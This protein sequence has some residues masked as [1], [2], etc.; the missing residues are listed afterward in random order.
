MPKAITSKGKRVG[1]APRVASKRPSGAAVQ[2]DA[3]F[4]IVGI[5]ASAGGYEA[6]V[7]LFQALPSDAG[8]AFVL[9]MHLEP[10]HESMLSV[11]LGNVTTMAVAEARNGMPV[12]P[13]HVYVI[14]PNADMTIRRGTLHL[15]PRLRSGSSH[16]PADQFLSSLA[17]DLGGR[18]I[19]VLLSGT[20][21]DG[22]NGLKAIKSEGGVTFA[23]DEATAKHYGMPGSAI[24]AGCVDFVLPPAR[25]AEELA[26][27]AGHPY[28]SPRQDA[29]TPQPPTDDDADI[30]KVIY[31]LRAAT[32]VDFS[33]YKTGTIRRRIAR[34]MA[35]RKIG[36]TSNYVGCLTADRTELQALLHDVLIHVTGFF[37]EPEA[38]KVLQ[39]RIFPQI[40]EKKGRDEAIRVWVPGC[41]TGEEVYSLAICLVEFLEDRV[42]ST[43]IQ[44]FGT[45]I[46]EQAIERARSGLYAES[47]VRDVSPARLRR[48]FRKTSGGYLVSS[49]IREMCIFARQDITKDPPFSHVDLI[50]CRNVLIYM[51]SAL[52]KRVVASFHY[53]LREGGFLL[54]SKSEALNTYSDLFAP[55]ERNTHVFIRKPTA[56]RPAPVFAPVNFERTPVSISIPEEPPFDALKEA[57]RLMWQRFSH[58]GLVLNDNLEILH[59]RGDT[60]PFVSPVSGKASLHVLRMVHDDL[61]LELRSA[62]HRVRRTNAPVRTAGIRLQHDGGTSE[63]DLEVQPLKRPGS[64]ERYFLILFEPS[65][66][67]A[68]PA[69]AGKARRK[70]SAE[71]QR[72]L[73]KLRRELEASREYLQSVVEQQEASNEEL[74]SANEEILS[75][76]EELQSTNEELETA[77]EELQSANEELVTLNETLEM[78]N[79]D[80]GKLTDD[81]NNVLD[82]A[83]IPILIVGEDSRIRR[84]TP[85][86]QGLLN[87]LPGDI[88]RPIGNIRPNVQITDLDALIAKVVRSFT[89]IQQEVQDEDGRWY[90]MRIRPYRTGENKIDGVLIAL[91]DIDAHKRANQALAGSEA[92]VRGLV[93]TLLR[94]IVVIDEAGTIVMV[95]AALEAMFGYRRE[96][97]LG[98]AMEILLPERLRAAHAEHRKKYFLS[99]RVRF[100]GVGLDL[101]GRKQDGTEFPTDVSLS[102][103]RKS[104][105]LLAVASILD[106]TEERKLEEAITEKDK[107]L[108]ASEQELQTLTASLLTAQE[109]ER[110]RL[111]RELHDDLN[112]H[113][114]ALSLNA[115]TLEQRL[116]DGGVR[117]Q[118]RSFRAEVEILSDHIRRLAHQLHPSVLEHFGLPKALR[119]Y[120]EEFAKFNDLKVRYRDS[121]LP[122]S[123]PPDIALCLYRVAQEALSNVAHHSRSKSASVVLAFAAGRIRLVVSDKGAGFDAA[124]ARARPGLGLLSMRERLRLVGGSLSIRTKL[125]EGTRVEAS[126]PLPEESA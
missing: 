116:P 118:I 72:E 74:K 114:A 61:K 112:Q 97:L 37:R 46:D 34:R 93:E 102:Y 90:S 27:L 47:A 77:K 120:C 86:A 117:D 66:Q 26:G 59:F 4:R 30:R 109:E 29:G 101:I 65:H 111:A 80:L 56:G 76:N 22:T 45:D 50:S 40:I 125:G 48:F 100:M 54:L 105:S 58:A 83:N 21:C 28:V 104:D 67:E 41:S 87:L 107:A 123:V 13:N 108:R 16:L 64:R 119:S 6:S 95:N 113:L 94:A 121:D 24:S 5:G 43:L 78:R 9:V 15:T 10:E 23:Q 126:I 8:M 49:S 70:R 57:D 99:P 51:G 69:P 44:V 91:V 98:Q 124:D 35:L 96:E 1:S 110:E 39:T 79:A 33:G 75:S 18:A 20:G 88:G 81:L 60:S 2:A 7:Q 19:G 36:S 122:A 82:G 84:F 3:A 85:S 92:M 14:P 17:N 52:Q 32:G 42:S 55:A 11:L 106:L 62:I 89:E 31:L 115:D 71:E 38:F 53:A 103:V 25:I 68:P 73:S 63:V 12:K